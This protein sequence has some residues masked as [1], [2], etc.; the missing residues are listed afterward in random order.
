[1]ANPDLKS[2]LRQFLASKGI[3]FDMVPMDVD[4]ELQKV[5]PRGRF[6]KYQRAAFALRHE[7]GDIHEVYRAMFNRSEANTLISQQAEVYLNTNAAALELVTQHLSPGMTIWEMGCMNGLC[8]EWLAENQPKIHVYGTDRVGQVLR[9]AGKRHTLKNLEYLVW[10]YSTGA[11]RSNHRKADIIYCVLGIEEP[12]N[13]SA[14]RSTDPSDLRESEYYK[15][16]RSQTSTWTSPDQG[17][18]EG[19]LVTSRGAGKFSRLR[20][21]DRYDSM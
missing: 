2:N 13:D 10:Y 19:L 12:V 18:V 3:R 4:A 20:R 21:H 7:G 15:M 6:N 14:H 5:M 11:P 17:E 9:D 16:N 1:M 8:A